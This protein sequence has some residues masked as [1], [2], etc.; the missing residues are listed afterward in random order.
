MFNSFLMRSPFSPPSTVSRPQP[1]RCQWGRACLS[2]TARSGLGRLHRKLDSHCSFP[3]CPGP[4]RRPPRV[5]ALCPSEIRGQRV[6]VCV[7]SAPGWPDPIHALC[8]G[9]GFQWSSGRVRTGVCLKPARSPRSPFLQRDIGWRRCTRPPRAMRRR[10]A[11]RWGGLCV[12]V[13]DSKSEGTGVREHFPP[14]GVSSQGLKLKSHEKARLIRN[15][16]QRQ[17]LEEIAGNVE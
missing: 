5:C 4:P 3:S 17:I 15:E 12:C 2:R 16:V 10:W 6:C 14:Q 9:C 11:V 1:V 7:F 8:P 13:C